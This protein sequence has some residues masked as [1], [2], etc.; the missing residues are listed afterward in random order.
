MSTISEVLTE[1]ASSVSDETLGD[2][3]MKLGNL[4]GILSSEVGRIVR[5]GLTSAPP[6]CN[7]KSDTLPE[8]QQTRASLVNTVYD[9]FENFRRRSVDALS[10]ATGLT[11]TAVLELISGNV[12]FRTSVGRESGKTYVSF[13]G[14]S[15]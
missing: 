15:R 4:D 12:D 8:D 5:A 11:P 14:L 3:A 6:C 9:S 2:L 10:L 7:T 13:S 1:V